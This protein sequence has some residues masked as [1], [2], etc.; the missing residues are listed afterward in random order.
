MKK[1]KRTLKVLEVMSKLVKRAMARARHQ[2]HPEKIERLEKNQ[3]SYF[4]SVLLNEA[5]SRKGAPDRGMWNQDR[6]IEM[7]SSMIMSGGKK[8]R[9]GKCKN[10][11]C[12]GSKGKQTAPKAAAQKPSTTK[13]PPKTATGAKKPPKTG[14]KNKTTTTTI[15]TTTT[16][17][18]T[19]TT[20]KATTRATTTRAP[21]KKEAPREQIKGNNQSNNQQAAYNYVGTAGQNQDI[22]DGGVPQFF[23][24]GSLTPTDVTKWGSGCSLHCLHG[25]SG[26]CQLCG[27]AACRVAPHEFECRQYKHCTLNVNNVC[28]PGE[29]CDAVRTRWWQTCWTSPCTSRCWYKG[30]VGNQEACDECCDLACREDDKYIGNSCF[31]CALCKNKWGP[32]TWGKVSPE[33]KY[34]GHVCWGRDSKLYFVNF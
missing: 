34:N 19:T 8:K 25:F 27:S 22:V 23:L 33:V 1:P 28:K 21:P 6:L 7:T 2:S 16:T 3:E 18:T 20:T 9:G 24:P 5:G 11:G 15:T 17:A 10:G 26:R 13:S 29:D 4:K 14:G 32:H 30:S 12:K 31:R